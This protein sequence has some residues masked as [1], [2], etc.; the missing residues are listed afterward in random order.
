MVLCHVGPCSL[1]FGQAKL[2]NLYL[3]TFN[4]FSGGLPK[5]LP[6]GAAQ[7]DGL[8]EG[9]DHHGGQAPGRQHKYT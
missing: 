4:L 3:E 1:P 8:E 2:N 5:A 9:G 7:L 6:G